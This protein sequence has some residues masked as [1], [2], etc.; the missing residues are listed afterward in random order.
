VPFG[1][2]EA[3]A[4]ESERQHHRH[5]E[6]R[7]DTTTAHARYRPRKTGSRFSVKAA[8]ASAVYL[9]AEVDRLRRAFVVECLFERDVHGVVQHALGL[10]DRN[11]WHRSEFLRP[12][13]DEGIEFHVGHD[14]IHEPDALGL[15]R[16]DDVGEEGEFFGT[17]QTNHDA[18]TTTIRR[19]RC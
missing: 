3:W 13:I 10:G 19:S 4:C 15:G 6:R 9:R 1:S 8:I 7:N 17:M 16:V 14:P 2:T 11:R 12:T 5:R 18:A